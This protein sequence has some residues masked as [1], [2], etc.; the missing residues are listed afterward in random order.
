MYIMEVMSQR[1]L[2]HK[3]GFLN[4]SVQLK[5]LEAMF[6]AILRTMKDVPVLTILPRMTSQYFDISTPR[7]RAKK[8]AAV[9]LVRNLISSELTAE[10][11]GYRIETPLGN[12]VYCP[13]ELVWCFDGEK[14]KDDLSDCLLQ[15][16]GF[17]EW[18]Q[19]AKGL[20]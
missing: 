4:I 5:S 18:S 19:M 7:S 2:M 9:G 20:I 13:E 10:D 6:Y 16:V 17:M 11:S 8:K 3:G 12:R 15:A 1:P 14:K